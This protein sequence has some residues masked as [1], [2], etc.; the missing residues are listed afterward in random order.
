MTT[1]TLHATRF[2]AETAEYRAARDRLLEAEVA[3]RANTEAVAAQR[4]S[5]PLGGEI[6]KDYV[7]DRWDA[8]EYDVRKVRLSELFAPGTDTLFLYSFMFNPGLKGAPLEVGCPSCTS[9]IDAVDGAARHLTQRI[10]FAVEG[11]TSIERFEAHARTRGWRH[12]RLLSSAGNTYRHDYN[13]EQS[14]ADQW[15]IATV[16]VRRDGRI[17]HWWSSELFYIPPEAG[18]D[19]RHVDFMWPMWAIFDATP[20]GRGDWSPELTYR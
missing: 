4:R 14:D 3:L 12:A 11:K 2:P 17:H 8:N 7:F 19:M 15:P 20:A 1:K 6:L 16:F 5:L 13:C 10:S 18:M 9:I